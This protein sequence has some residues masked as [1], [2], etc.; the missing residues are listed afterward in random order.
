MDA[1]IKEGEAGEVFRM[2]FFSTVHSEKNQNI[3]FSFMK[4]HTPS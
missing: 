1:N 2:F 3:V 4:A